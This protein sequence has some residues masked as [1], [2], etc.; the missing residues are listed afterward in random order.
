MQ[1]ESHGCVIDDTLCVAIDEKYI[2]KQK[3]LA[4]QGEKFCQMDQNPGKIV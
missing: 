1:N 4:P 3:I 2:G